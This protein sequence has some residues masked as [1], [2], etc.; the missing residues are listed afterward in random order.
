M[1][2]TWK[3]MEVSPDS[4]G[5]APTVAGLVGYL[6]SVPDLAALLADEK[7]L[8]LRGF[9]VT[10]DELDA[11]MDL[12][13]PNRLSYVHGN[14]PR[15]KVGDNVYTSTEYPSRYTISMHGELSYAAS[16]PS[17][18][19]FYCQVAAETGGATPVLDARRWLEVLDPEVRDA[20]AGG[21]RY[22]QLLHDGTGLGKSWRETFE[23]DDRA[24]VERFLADS[25]AA[26]EWTAD[27]L[28]VSHTRP[29]TAR[30]PVTGT[31][32]WFNQVDQWH[33]AG[34][35]DEVARVMSEVMKPEELPQ[36]V[37]FADGSPI[38]PEYVT[39]IRDRG[40]SAAV[41]VAWRPGDVLVIDNV[42]VAHGRRPYT[43]DRRVLVAMSG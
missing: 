24:E 13:L 35:E 6:D 30:H 33:P 9:G 5:N 7:A 11:V 25:D 2:D 3:P 39:Q 10:P 29:A 17:R 27:G 8:L 37:T 4:T 19:M 41:D 23:T 40:L 18:L 34:L 14:S 20:F 38:P 12:L 28:R 26:F 16:W 36:Y 1:N 32:V 22:L 21:V 43:G 42:L 15:T 31:E